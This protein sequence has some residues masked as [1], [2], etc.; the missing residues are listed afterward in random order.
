MPRGRPLEGAPGWR[1]IEHPRRRSWRAGYLILPLALVAGLVQVFFLSDDDWLGWSQEPAQ[2]VADNA[3][4]STGDRA[5]QALL[6]VPHRDPEP[7]ASPLPVPKPSGP[8]RRVDSQQS[9]PAV[10]PPSTVEVPIRVFIHHTAGDA[11]PAIQL[12][13]FLETHGFDVANIR[14]VRFDIDRPSVRYFFDSDQPGCRRLVEAVDAFFAKAPDR[15][16]ARAADFTAFSPKPGPGSV[17][18]W[19]SGRRGGGSQSS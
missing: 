7:E 3:P 6:A 18:V 9:T 17:E 15:A 4:S 8:T 13:A 19:L 1:V 16:P 12:A 10:A 11:L 2:N 5:V 14:S